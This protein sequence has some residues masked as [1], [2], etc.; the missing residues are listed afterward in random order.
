MDDV[1]RAAT[2]AAHQYVKC[3]FDIV[4]DAINKLD[5]EY[6]ANEY[7]YGFFAASLSAVANNITGSMFYRK[8]NKM[9]DPNSDEMKNLSK[10]ILVEALRIIDNKDPDSD[11]GMGVIK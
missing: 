5:F 2:I 7:V 9:P 1:E 4:T 3:L 11:P 10:S 8:N 6:D